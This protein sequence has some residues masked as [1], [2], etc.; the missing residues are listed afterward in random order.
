MNAKTAFIIIKMYYNIN[1]I[2]KLSKNLIYY[3]L[4]LMGFAIYLKKNKK[5]KYTDYKL[6]NR[7][8]LSS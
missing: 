8:N 1:L 2:H 7:D 6:V 5:I 3:N 4:T